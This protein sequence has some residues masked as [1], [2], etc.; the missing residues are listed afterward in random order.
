MPNASVPG[1]D[2]RDHGGRSEGK[3]LGEPFQ[4]R[5]VSLAGLAATA[6]LAKS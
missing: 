2:G 5:A 6:V 1:D 3:R 4:R